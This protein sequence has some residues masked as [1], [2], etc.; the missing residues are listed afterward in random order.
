[1]AD[2]V[3]SALTAN[4]ERDGEAG[5]PPGQDL[6]G[7]RGPLGSENGAQV[8]TFSLRPAPHH[9]PLPSLTSKPL[10]SVPDAFKHLEKCALQAPFSNSLA[11]H[12]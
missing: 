8:S 5:S 4:C 11:P 12:G 9:P 2:T 6:R 1:M 7:C 10:G 3:N